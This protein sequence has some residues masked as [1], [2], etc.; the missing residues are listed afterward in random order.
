MKG[1]RYRLLSRGAKLAYALATLRDDP[2]QC[3]GCPMQVDPLQLETHASRCPGN[4][5]NGVSA[6]WLSSAAVLELGVSDSVLSRWGRSG[7]VQR[8]MGPAGW[9]Y[10]HGD[11]VEAIEAL[12]EHHRV[13]RAAKAR[14]RVMRRWRMYRQMEGRRQRRERSRSRMPR[15]KVRR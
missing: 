5:W 3:P 4:S 8:R 14:R 7:K 10:W 15:R 12:L 11:L 2:V 1:D 13:R 9:L 6:G